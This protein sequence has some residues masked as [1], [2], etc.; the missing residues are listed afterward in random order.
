MLFRYQTYILLRGLKITPTPKRNI[1]QVR[2]DIHNYTRKL[3]L[4]EFFHNAPE[5]NNLQNLFKTKSN[6]TPPT[7]RDRDLD[8]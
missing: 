6:F 5:H 8:H 2:S 4:T 3:R 7:N 1:I